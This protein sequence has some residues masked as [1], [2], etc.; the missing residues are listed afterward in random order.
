MSNDEL[1]EDVQVYAY[2]GPHLGAVP[3][4]RKVDSPGRREVVFE[5]GT[6]LARVDEH[7]LRISRQ[8]FLEA[9]AEDFDHEGK[10][11]VDRATGKRYRLVMSDP[12]LSE[13]PTDTGA[14]LFFV[15]GEWL[16]Y[17]R[18]RGA[19]GRS[20]SVAVGSVGLMKP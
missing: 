15:S 17:L 4:G 3:T 20:R 7:R 8:H 19:T 5:C 9:N 14:E 16:V 11:W 13:H 10:D 2:E 12:T 1:G 18:P 6:G